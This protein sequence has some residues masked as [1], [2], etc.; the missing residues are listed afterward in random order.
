M[1]QGKLY[2][3]II[4][5]SGVSLDTLYTYK[6]FFKCSFYENESIHPQKMLILVGAGTARAAENLSIFEDE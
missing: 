4:T 2:H 3:I 5:R 1:N 6:D